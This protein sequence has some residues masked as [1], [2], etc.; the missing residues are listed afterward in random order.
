ML[1][2]YF[3]TVANRPSP[4]LPPNRLR[5]HTVGARSIVRT[6]GTS[7]RALNEN[8]GR[9]RLA[10]RWRVLN[11]KELSRIGQR[12]E[13]KFSARLSRSRI[14]ATHVVR[15][16]NWGRA[17]RRERT[18]FATYGVLTPWVADDEKAA[19][20]QCPVRMEER[21]VESTISINICSM[22]DMMM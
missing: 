2:L 15:V 21:K 3:Q 22:N 17:S 13:V 18:C 1:T 20:G 11:I 12:R 14:P 7:Q 5:V 8:W 10:Y 4:K 9:P 16:A 19:S 6:V